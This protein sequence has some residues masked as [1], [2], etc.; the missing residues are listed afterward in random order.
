M[1]LENNISDE[2]LKLIDR[3][4]TSFGDN[5]ILNSVVSDG[6]FIEDLA[7]SQFEFARKALIDIDRIDGVDESNSLNEVLQRLIVECK[8]LEEPNKVKL[9]EI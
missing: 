3:K 8:K 9:E 1:K 6:D 2:L 4:K 5:S 7:T